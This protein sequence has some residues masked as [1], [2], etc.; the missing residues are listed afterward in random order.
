M[1]VPRFCDDPVTVVVPYVG[2]WGTGKIEALPH[3][4]AVLSASKSYSERLFRYQRIDRLDRLA[5]DRALSAP[6]A[7][8]GVE[9]Q[10]KALDA[11]YDASGGYP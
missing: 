6:A 7:R 1:T 5:A 2:M 11:L 8:E 3:L 10:E 9:Y 4:P